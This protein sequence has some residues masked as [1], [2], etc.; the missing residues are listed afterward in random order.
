MNGSRISL[1]D[2]SVPAR[3][4]DGHDDSDDAQTRASSLTNDL[5]HPS[6]PIPTSANNDS[7]VSK[8]LDIPYS[9]YSPRQKWIIALL[10]TSVGMF[11]PLGANIYF[12]AIP[13]LS[14][15]FVK[16]VQDIKCVVSTF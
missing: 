2:S 13:S 4:D 8:D 14:A 11:S 7:N 1:N 15:A 5:S 16:S 9:I 6:T 3:L 12:P 10:A